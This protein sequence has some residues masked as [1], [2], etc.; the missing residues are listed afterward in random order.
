MH[1]PLRVMIA[2]Y[3]S[4]FVELD[5]FHL[6]CM[7]VFLEGFAPAPSFCMGAFPFPRLDFPIR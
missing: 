6:E 5:I 4:V 3:L 7:E 2:D 1:F